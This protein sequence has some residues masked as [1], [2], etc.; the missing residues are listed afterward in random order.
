[1]PAGGVGPRMRIPGAA[2]GSASP[3]SAARRLAHTRP[4]RRREREAVPREALWDR[5]ARW[6]TRSGTSCSACLRRT[7]PP[8]PPAP[9]R[10]KRA[11]PRAPGDP[12]EGAAGPGLPCG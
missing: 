3:R 4:G 1:M 10:V 8:P 9:R 6:R 7:R 5:P 11:P 12:G 2:G